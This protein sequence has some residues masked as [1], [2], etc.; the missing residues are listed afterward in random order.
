MNYN[1]IYKKEIY[2]K[3]INMSLIKL[4]RKPKL[5]PK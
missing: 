3:N 1:Y 5:I 2:N 4:I